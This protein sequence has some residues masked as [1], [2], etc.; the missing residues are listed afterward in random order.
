MATLDRPLPRVGLGR[1]GLRLPR[2]NW[3]ITAAT[4]TFLFGA[5]LPV[6]QSSATTSRGFEIRSL[7]QR[8]QELQAEIALL[9]AQIAEEGSLERVRERAAALGLKPAEDPI[10]VEVDVPGPVPAQVPARYLPEAAPAA[11]RPA[12]W[13]QSLF[14]WLPLPD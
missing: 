8:R 14:A 2:W 11:E 10:V 6:L 3:W 1:L 13:W 12:P 7:E 9:Q 4:L 5:A